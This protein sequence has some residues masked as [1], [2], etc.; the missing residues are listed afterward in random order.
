VFVISFY[1]WAAVLNG[2]VSDDVL[3]N[4]VEK[5]KVGEF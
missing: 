5:K 3:T 1:V 2:G 4:E